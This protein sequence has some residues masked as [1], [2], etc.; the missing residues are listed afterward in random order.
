MV[1]QSTYMQVLN[2][3][4]KRYIF[5]RSGLE[6]RYN[7]MLKLK[8]SALDTKLVDLIN[9]VL[10]SYKN[11][12]PDSTEID[13]DTLSIK[14][15]AMMVYQNS[16][17]EIMALMNSKF[18]RANLKSYCTEVI[19]FGHSETLINQSNRIGKSVIKFT[20]IDLYTLSE[21]TNIIKAERNRKVS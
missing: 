16:Y 17:V 10:D 9:D 4:E 13:I 8:Q 7:N 18:S 5:T 1:K 12:V 14:K 11:L 15:C 20:R 21:I 19:K 3:L 6:R 2:E